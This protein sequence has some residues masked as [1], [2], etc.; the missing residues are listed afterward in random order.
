MTLDTKKLRGMI[1]A[2]KHENIIAK[3]EAVAAECGTSPQ[4]LLR[5]ITGNPYLWDRLPRKVAE[6][7][8]LSR[9]L[10]EYRDAQ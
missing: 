4:S 8:A 10:D 6:I 5:K 1:C 7:D 9:K 3:V 2:M